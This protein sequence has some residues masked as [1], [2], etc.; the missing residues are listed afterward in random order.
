MTQIERK[1]AVVTCISSYRMRYAVPVDELQKMNTEVPIEGLET[2]WAKDS[3]TMG[4]VKE[5]SQEWLGEKIIDANLMS[6]EDI[7][8]LFDADND[9]LSG[10]T[11]DKK[12]EWIRNW[13]EKL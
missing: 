9:Y 2:E 12:I 4:E 6:E 3:V 7:L 13:E 11:K 8:K 10:W 1:Y 5:F